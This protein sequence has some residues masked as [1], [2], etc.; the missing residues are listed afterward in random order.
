LER[1][2]ELTALTALLAD[3]RGG[4]GRLVAIE[5][6]A[7]IGKT[8][9]LQEARTAA[10]GL[11]IRVLLA[12]GGE[13]ERDFG[14]GVVRQLLEPA[15]EAADDGERSELLAGA[16][17]LAEPVFAPA[18]GAP[19]GDSAHAALHGLYWLLVNLSER[20]PLLVAVDDLQWA[21]GPSL[22][23][24]HHLARR[25]D[26]LPIALLACRRP[27][28]RGPE[29]QLL[30][31]LVLESE[32]LRPAALSSDAVAA[33]VRGRLGETAGS[34]LC[35]AC[36]ESSGGN[37]FLL[38]ELLSELG[39]GQR[40]PSAIDAAS[41]RR[42]GP[43]RIATAVLLRVGRLGSGARALARSVA[44]LGEMAPLAAA[45]AL[46]DLDPAAAARLADS[47][48]EL[49]VL[50]A[51]HPLRFAHPVVR[52]AIYED[53]A[54]GER[55]L[56]HRRAAELAAGE[57]EQAAVHLLAT[58]PAGSDETVTALRAAGRS[59]LGR[60]AP[61]TAV[62]CL[63]RALAEPPRPATRPKV[64]HE[65][66]SA[67][68]QVGEC[69]ALE[70]T[71]EAFEL[72]QEQPERAAIGAEHGA[73]LLNYE[74]DADAAVAVFE[75]SLEGLED[76]ELRRRLEAL[77]L[78]AGITTASA[79]ARAKDRMRE[80]RTVL[81]RVEGEQTQLL[82]TPV[83]IE[84]AISNGTAA[85]A[86]HLARRALAG[87][88]LM[89]QCAAAFLP[90]AHLAGV[91]LTYSGELDAA[92][93]TF[94]DVIEHFRA[95]GSLTAVAAGC[96]FRADV[97]YLAGDLAA[98]EAD[99]RL[100][101]EEP[102]AAA[103]PITNGVATAALVST[104]IEYGRPEIARRHLESLAASGY[105][106]EVLPSQVLRRSRAQLLATE[107]DHQGALDELAACER[108]EREWSLD[109]GVTPVAWRSAA[110]LSHEALGNSAE[111]RRL[112]GEELEL[113]RRFGAP[114]A[115]GVALRTHGLVHDDDQETLAEAVDVLED[116][117]ARLEH[118][119]ALVALGSAQRRTGH[120]SVARK[121]LAQA[122]DLANRA[123]ATALLARARE[124]Q[125]L[126]G[127]RPRRI[128]QTGRAAL[129]P[130]ELRVA[131]LAAQST[132]NKQI[133]QALFVTQRTVEMHLSN[134]YR[135][136]GIETREQLAAALTDA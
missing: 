44:V 118:A 34:D 30:D 70:W 97:H 134:S 99:A 17:S 35:D 133:A 48:T 96:A 128:A 100:C 88:G 8:R 60:G 15:L 119:R 43:T 132:T 55:A 23:F 135:K 22:R 103:W 46:A 66:G 68:N 74:D 113:S 108:F 20:S 7:G 104:Q 109:V 94:D 83:A 72:T 73:Q 91:A 61:E 80:A 18:A 58:D 92:E 38:W 82:A 112:A 87:G 49:G 69:R 105:N 54:P 124:E 56:M 102:A 107:G 114:R 116:S 127:A 79:R 101:I 24:L 63:R 39:G 93:H 10:E 86:A 75:R 9:L 111:A 89:R 32:L 27:G 5:G 117:G 41:V 59:A 51:G 64:L 129:T 65:L 16:A 121:T 67:A 84:V 21:D 29:S 1:D 122:A 13:L 25:L 85:A 37:P 28:E 33:I 62:N 77:L 31:S 130:G 14:F 36:H 123:G 57:S 131:E 110:A 45:A 53:I 26:G 126:A 47:L 6:P 40:P 120:R 3:A 78:W 19:T 106:P 4:H 125:R 2:A 71:R 50:T 11:G 76:R 98:A 136:L 115:L 95:R 81:E 12:R 42:L 90:F 52:T